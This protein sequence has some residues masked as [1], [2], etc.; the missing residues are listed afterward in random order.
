MI[1]SL[2]RYVRSVIKS[3]PI[4]SV[5]V[6]LLAIILSSCSSN[7]TVQSESQIN[8][9]THYSIVCIIHGDGDYLYHDTNGNEFTADKE[10]LSD[11]KKVAVQNP[12][13]EVFIFHQRPAQSFLF[14]FPL[15]DGDF[16]YYRNGQLLVNE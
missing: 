5:S 15:R 4:A 14:F 13:A 16:Y 7:L 9:A 2:I 11:I 1:N 8:G 12:D 6:I 3:R 10:V